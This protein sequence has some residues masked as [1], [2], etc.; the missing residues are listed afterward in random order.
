L[1]IYNHGSLE[2]KGAADGLGPSPY[3]DGDD[4]VEAV[5]IDPNDTNILYAGKRS[6]HKGPSSGLYR[7]V[8]AGQSWQHVDLVQPYIEIWA[9]EINPYNSDV[10]I[11][12]SYGLYKIVKISK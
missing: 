1:Y 12:T 5:A 7:S 4:Y 2:L 6:R 8:D 10:Y 9:V 3:P 11:G